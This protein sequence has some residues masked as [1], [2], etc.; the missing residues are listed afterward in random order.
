[1][2]EHDHDHDDDPGDDHDHGHPGHEHG[3]G[4]GHHHDVSDVSDARLLF[5]IALNLGLTGVEVV[6]GVLSGSLGLIADAVHNFNDSAA[7]LIA[8]IA[9]RV[10]R[11]EAD[12]RYTFGYRRAELIGAMINL[13]MLVV[14]GLYLIYESVKRLLD[15]QPVQGQW[16]MIA[17]G[18]ALVVDVGTAALL[19]AMSKGN[20]NVRAAFVHNLTDAGA[21]LAVL[22][23]GL[24]IWLGGPSWV[25][26]LLGLGIA[27]YILYT[28]QGMLRQTASI[29]MESSPPGLSL[30]EVR[31]AMERVDGVLG[32]H[33]VHAWQLDEQHAA[34]EAHIIVAEPLDGASMVRI[35]S[36]LKRLL[37]ERFELTHSTLEFELAGEEC[38]G[39][40]QPPC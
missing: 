38:A 10:G 25:D 28:C 7:L 16:V 20:L 2:S 15:P 30:D 3:H 26:P 11:W 18:V 40:G 14:V 17:A 24:V 36:R 6:A 32:V 37:T 12:E 19:W 31:Q 13:T 23:G 5:S 39:R 1:M 34:L 29:L 33:H 27:A 35:K 21:S 9:R 8:Y 22:L 4:H